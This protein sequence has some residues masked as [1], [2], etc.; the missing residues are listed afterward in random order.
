QAGLGGGSSDAAA[1]LRALA[2]LY[3]GVAAPEALAELGAEI[4]SDVPLFLAGSSLVRMRGRG[5]VVEPL[6]LPLPPLYGV[7]VQPDIGVATADA[8]GLLDAMEDRRP[9]GATPSL[10][11]ALR[12]G[13][14][15]ADDLAGFLANDFETVV[16]AHYPEVAAA[17]RAVREAGALRALLCGSGSA[18]F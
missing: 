2:E 12:E 15:T 4:G 6:A 18:V 10:L 8:Y 7:L 13:T 17:Y 5:E 14:E 16:L 1:V 11:A 3:P 9:G